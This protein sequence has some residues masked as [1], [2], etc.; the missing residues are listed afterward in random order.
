MA[1]FYRPIKYKIGKNYL[2][3]KYD[4]NKR[5]LYDEAFKE[6]PIT[7]FNGLMGFFLN[8]REQLAISSLS[9][10]QSQVT[11]SLKQMT[12]AIKETT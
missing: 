8:L 12:E 2:L 9:Y 10:F 4:S 11:D 3:E 6:V 7:Y 1:V 5:A